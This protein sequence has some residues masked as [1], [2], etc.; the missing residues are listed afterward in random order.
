MA[1]IEIHHEHGHTDDPLAKRVGLMV[2][3]IGVALAVVTI[4]AHREHTAAVIDRTAEN[5][6]WAYYQAKKIREHMSSVGRELAVAL[7][8][9][10]T[11][12]DAAVKKFEEQSAKYKKDAEEL[13]KEARGDEAKTETAEHRALR[14]DL[15][16]GFI[17]LGLVLSSLYFLGRQ[18]LFPLIGGV[19]AV[20]G[21]AVALSALAL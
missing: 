5:D 17:E 11:R 1:E 15:G 7:G 16:E 20:L 18:R 19:S 21:L 12:V 14:F 4:A 8:S 2:G 3:I 9:D 6:A 13:E 10:A